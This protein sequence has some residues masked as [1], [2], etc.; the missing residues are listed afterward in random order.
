[1]IPSMVQSVEAMLG[2][3][4]NFEG[5]EIDVSEEFRL[6]TAEVI[7]RTTFGSSYVEGIQIFHML[8][9]FVI[10]AHKN[11]HKVRLPILR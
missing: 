3:W 7:S 8:R 2:R 10:L 4:K 11:S 1:M 6:L 5:K 9:T